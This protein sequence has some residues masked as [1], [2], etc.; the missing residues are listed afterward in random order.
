LQ[1]TYG[2]GNPTPTD[3]ALNG[4]PCQLE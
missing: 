3:F 2:T 4:A 1:A